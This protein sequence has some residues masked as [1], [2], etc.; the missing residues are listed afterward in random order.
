MNKNTY[1]D[2]MRGKNC[3]GSTI[4]I[5]IYELTALR[6]YQYE[7][8]KAVTQINAVNRIN[9]IKCEYMQT[10]MSKYD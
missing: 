7:K 2:K 1:V 8:K 4:G 10:N 5:W 9:A 6:K 3:K